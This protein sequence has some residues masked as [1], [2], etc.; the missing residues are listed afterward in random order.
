LLKK[1]KKGPT[2]AE[3]YGGWLCSERSAE[4]RQAYQALLLYWSIVIYALHTLAGAYSGCAPPSFFPF[5]SRCWA[6]EPLAEVCRCL[7][8]WLADA[9]GR[10]RSRTANSC[11]VPSWP[12]S[13]TGAVP[14]AFRELSCVPE[15]IAAVARCGGR[16]ARG[17]FQIGAT[18]LFAPLSLRRCGF[19]GRLLS[20]VRA[21]HGRKP[22]VS[23]ATGL[24]ECITVRLICVQGTRCGTGRDFPAGK[25]D[26][27]V[28]TATSI[29]SMGNEQRKP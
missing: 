9:P 11:P 16:D 25:C 24:F 4:G 23:S 26:R 20:V 17:G 1:L 29:G 3:Q 10:C 15:D 18:G 28:K 5:I 19:R 21:V 27:G 22:R 2:P 8:V 14:W 6:C 7:K 13:G 12:L